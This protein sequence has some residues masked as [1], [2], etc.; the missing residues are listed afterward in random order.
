MRKDK[1]GKAQGP[2]QRRRVLDLSGLKKWAPIQA[3]E[4][5]LKMRDMH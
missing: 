3:R 1:K 5:K 2:Y 4:L